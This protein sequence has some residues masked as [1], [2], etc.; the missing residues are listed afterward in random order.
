MSISQKKDD[1]HGRSQPGD[2]PVPQENPANQQ[3]DGSQYPAY[4][5]GTVYST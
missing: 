1:Y 5:D 2:L 4:N 3:D